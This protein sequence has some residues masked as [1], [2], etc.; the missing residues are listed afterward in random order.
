MEGLVEEFNDD[1]MA[2]CV[3]TPRETVPPYYPNYFC[4]MV[5]ERG[6]LETA[7]YLLS[8]EDPQYGLARLWELDRLDLS[9]EYLVLRRRYAPLFIERE[10]AEAKKRL[11]DYRMRFPDPEQ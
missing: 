8:T 10:L 6:G 9:V 2:L 11:T 7:K 3:R 1:M 4:R 5:K